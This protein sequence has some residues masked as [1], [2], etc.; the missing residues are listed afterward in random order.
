M[1]AGTANPFTLAACDWLGLGVVAADPGPEPIC[2]GIPG[3]KAAVG[4]SARSGRGGPSRR[5][6]S[7]GDIGRYRGAGSAAGATDPAWVSGVN[8]GG[9]ASGC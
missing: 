8:R 9:V 5:V 4:S 7:L 2:A 1:V 3:P 6:A